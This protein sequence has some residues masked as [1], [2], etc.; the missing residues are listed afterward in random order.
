MFI[1]YF[2]GVGLPCHLIFRQFWLCEEPQC[3]YLRRHLGSP[4]V[5][6]F[7]EPAPGFIDLYNCSFILYVI[8]FCSDLGYFLPCTCS[9]LSLLLFLKFL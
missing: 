5:Y 3:V 9:G 6:L 8:L 1:F 4:S 7:K 2:L